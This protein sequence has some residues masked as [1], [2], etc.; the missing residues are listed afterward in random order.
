MIRVSQTSDESVPPKILEHALEVCRSTGRYT[1]GSIVRELESRIAQ[2]FGIPVPNVVATSSWTTGAVIAF[3][4]MF[5]AGA[6]VTVFAPS[7]TFAATYLP[8]LWRHNTRI[9]LVP[10]R[11]DGQLSSTQLSN[12]LEKHKNNKHKVICNT[13]IYGLPSDY[14]FLRSMAEEYDA[15]IFSDSAQALGSRLGP[16]YS[17][18]YVGE[19]ATIHVFSM[20]ATKPVTAIEGGLVVCKTTALA[21]AVRLRRNYGMSPSGKQALYRRGLNA[22]MSEIHA[23]VAVHNVNRMD[24][25]LLRRLYTARAYISCLSGTSKNVEV[26]ISDHTR[27]QTNWCYFPVILDSKCRSRVQRELSRVG[28][29]TRPYFN[30]TPQDH[31]ALLLHI[32]ANTFPCENT[33]RLTQSVLCL[34]LHEGVTESDA[35]RIVSKLLEILDD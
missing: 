26:L 18:P 6:P 10:C 25:M 34:P 19:Q 22:R 5:P 32:T 4:A 8:F 31:Q 21:D 13:D 33:K 7:Y 35:T 29:E 16:Y 24:G 12:L 14:D 11:T 15:R 27:T 1:N 20:S 9:I 23:A 17:S 2:L 28:I 3:D 30:A